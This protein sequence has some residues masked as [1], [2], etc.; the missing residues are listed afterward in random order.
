M[1]YKA[2]AFDLDGTLVTE[3]SSW[4]KLHKHFGTYEFSLKNMK[5]YEQ[6]EITYDKFMRL[7]I[8]LWKP[9]PRIST[10][11]EVLLS[12]HLTPN[13][14]LVTKILKEK[15]YS[16]FI[17]TTAPNI[18]ADAVAAE[19]NISNVASNGFIFD[20]DGYLTQNVLFN[21]DLMKKEIAFD[22]LISGRGMKCGDCIAVGDSK[23]DI[24]F[25]RKA[26]LGIAFSPDDT[27]RKEAMLTI[28]DMNELLQYI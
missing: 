26:G 18:L 11:K 6:G 14:K 9:R 17:V 13:S 25:L 16:L 27:L 24:G 23:Y 19:L 8:G 3:K 21:V 10:I 28:D 20:N 12:Y 4:Y 15:G 1:V 5:L 2:V 7:D 22:K